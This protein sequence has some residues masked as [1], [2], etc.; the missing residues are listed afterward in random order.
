MHAEFSNEQYVVHG[1]ANGYFQRCACTFIYTQYTA[2]CVFILLFWTT[3]GTWTQRAFTHL[4]TVGE[5]N[6]QSRIC[7]IA[8]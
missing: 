7:E 3:K 1:M 4:F 5:T 8:L 2:E 6:A